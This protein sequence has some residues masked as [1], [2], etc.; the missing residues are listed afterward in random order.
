LD[1]ARTINLYS[2]LP[3][4]FQA[5]LTEISSFYPTVRYP[6]TPPDVTATSSTNPT[7]VAVQVERV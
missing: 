3:S 2:V 5:Q 4:E 1:I 6:G 7:S